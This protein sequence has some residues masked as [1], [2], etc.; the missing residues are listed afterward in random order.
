MRASSNTFIQGRLEKSDEAGMIYFKNSAKLRE[1][2][3]F[4]V[5]K[6]SSGLGTKDTMQLIKSETDEQGFTHN[7]YHQHYEGIKVEGGEVFEHSK[8]CYVVIV[9]GIII[10]GLSLSTSPVLTQQQALA[11]A[12]GYLNATKY[13]W[14]DPVGT[15][16]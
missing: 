12:I 2:E 4:T 9:N 3:L 16:Y 13:A 7:E 6:T 5:Y 8:S 1:G 15:G 11:A 14:E 10:E